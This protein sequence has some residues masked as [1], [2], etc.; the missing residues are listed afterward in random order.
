MTH[1]LTSL[2]ILL[3]G[4]G[5]NM[6][7]IV[8]ACES[9]ELP[10]TVA[11][12][13]SNRIDAAGVAWTRERGIE[14]RVLP[15]RDYEGRDAHDRA[16]VD[17]LREAGVEWVCLAGYMRLLSPVFV[18]A[19]HNRILNIHPSLLPSFPGLDAQAQA[20]G[21]GVRWTGCTVHLVDTELDHGPIVEQTAVP[22]L[23]GDT[24]EDLEHRILLEEHPTYVRALKQLL[25][26]RWTLQG[27]RLIWLD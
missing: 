16:I 17:E 19:F 14:C 3:S 27:R 13:V 22:V 2:G 7:A 6:Q 24:V 8:R 20:H 9:G 26:R 11:I 10:A 1:K 15:H 25:Q 18:T 5:S 4:R 12:V 23:S 21:H